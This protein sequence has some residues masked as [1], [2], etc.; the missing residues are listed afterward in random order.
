MIIAI[1]GPSGAGKS[2][3]AN[4][5]AK[6]LGF[7]CL[8]TG[9][10][11]RAI[12]WKAVRK[13]INLSDEDGLE[14]IAIHDKIAFVHDN[15]PRYK[16]IYIDD[17]KITDEIRTP[18]ID[19]AV[20]PVCKHAKVRKALLEQQREIANSGN[21]VVDGRDIGTVVFPN[22]ELKI[23]LTA[24]VE[25]RA[26]RRF[27]QNNKEQD[28]DYILEDLKRRDYEDSHREVAPLKAADDAIILDSTN[29]TQE[30]VVEKI[31]N[32]VN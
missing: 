15:N 22:A 26:N 13:N 25:E 18:E 21:Y 3:V 16:D 1:D 10:M 19:R 28:Y 2:S 29:M 4:D 31:C 8:D 5:V 17:D 6:K 27:L 12:A 20:T 24:D 23:F 7:S 14:Q 32:L 30:E 9:A 11:F